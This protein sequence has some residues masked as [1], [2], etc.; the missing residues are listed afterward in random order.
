MKG[1]PSDEVR[2]PEVWMSICSPGR[3]ESTTNPAKGFSNFT[4]NA[5]HQLSSPA[6]LRNKSASGKSHG[7]VV[8]VAEKCFSTN[9]T[10]RG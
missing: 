2:K 1:S 4:S 10:N 5:M 8:A 6:K 7:Y 3:A 9:Q